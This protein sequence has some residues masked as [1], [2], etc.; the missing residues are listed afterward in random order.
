MKRRKFHFG[1]FDFVGLIIFCVLWFI[2]LRLLLIYAITQFDCVEIVASFGASHG[3]PSAF[4]MLFYIT[5]LFGLFWIII[6]IQKSLRRT[7]SWADTAWHLGLL[8]G[9]FILGV[10]I[11]S[12]VPSQ[13]MPPPDGTLVVEIT[14][15]SGLSIAN[16]NEE[17]RWENYENGQWYAD[18]RPE[19]VWLDKNIVTT[20]GSQDWPHSIT[21]PDL[22]GLGRPH[23]DFLQDLQDY[24][25]LTPYE[26]E[27]FLKKQACQRDMTLYGQPHTACEREYLY[28]VSPDKKPSVEWLKAMGYYELI[29]Q[30]NGSKT[31]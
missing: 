21:M 25:P 31:K 3:L 11:R 28:P 16:G 6:G 23:I 13:Y 18:G 2:S 17:A 12:Y 30:Q 8:I 9:I 22:L 26:R 4:A 19:C 1:I 29:P 27:R 5:I 14:P 7:V 15:R 24:R 20:H 10:F